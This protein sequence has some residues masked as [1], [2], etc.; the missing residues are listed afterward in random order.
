[1]EGQGRQ[2]LAVCAAEGVTLGGF[3]DD[4]RLLDYRSREPP[5]DVATLGVRRSA[6]F[7][8]HAPLG[9]SGAR[10]RV[11]GME[12]VTRL[13]MHVAARGVQSPAV[14]GQVRA[15]VGLPVIVVFVLDDDS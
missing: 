6:L 9:A 5:V 1:D 2:Q 10:L 7:G 3:F 14:G 8:A 12:L 13:L 11:E 4:G 15:A